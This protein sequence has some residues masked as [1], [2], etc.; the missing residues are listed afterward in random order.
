VRQS[1]IN[2]LVSGTG[3]FPI[4]LP[5][6]LPEDVSRWQDK[7]FFHVHFPH[8]DLIIHPHFNYNIGAEF[9]ATLI[10]TRCQIWEQAILE[11]AKI[12]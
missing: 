3:I 6:L 12:S 10:D 4:Y 11:K 9:F 5:F 2:L 1:E 8:V 7:G